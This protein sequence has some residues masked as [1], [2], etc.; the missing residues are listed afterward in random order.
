MGLLP[1]WMRDAVMPLY[2]SRVI[3]GLAGMEPPRHVGIMLDGNR[4]WA[5]AA[6]HRDVAEGYRVGGA[7]VGE[8]L[9]WC[10]DAG[11]EHVSL[12][13]LSDD[14]MAGRPEKELVPLLGI[15]Q[16][17]VAGLAASGMPW[18]VRVIGSLDLLPAEHAAALKEAA[19]ATEARG[20]MLVDVAVGYGGR[21]EIVDAVR[22]AFRR[23][24]EAGGDPA[25]L[26]DTIDID[27]ISANL[28]NSHGA[29]RTDLIIRTSGEQRLSGFLLWQS[30][31]SEMYFEDV[32]W[33][34][35]RRVDF[36]RALRSYGLRE[37]RFG[38]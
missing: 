15:I 18:R 10:Q 34:D 3:K 19:A 7:K 27:H 28:Y 12:F 25:E 37:R 31:Y 35:F 26:A 36:L 17:T 30:A 13:M 24:I 21:R 20:G 11:V 9:G 23:H 22:T 14:N 33:P 29:D 32:C 2:E 16:D 1:T 5:R 6:G 38:K 8:F 4:R